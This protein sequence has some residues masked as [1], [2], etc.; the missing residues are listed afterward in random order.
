MMSLSDKNKELIE[1]ALTSPE[2]QK[3]FQKVMKE[4]IKISKEYEDV[5]D[6]LIRS[7]QDLSY[8]TIFGP[9]EDLAKCVLEEMEEKMVKGESGATM[10]KIMRQKEKIIET[11][12]QKGL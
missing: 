1:R 6:A 4:P 9:N 12:N 7:F 5:A 11:I 2:G 8:E 3:I 10:E